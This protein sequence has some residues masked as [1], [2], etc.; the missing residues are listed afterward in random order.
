MSSDTGMDST[1][2][3]TRPCASQSAFIFARDS[4]GQTSPGF[5]SYTAD[6]I[7]RIPGICEMY[8]R[9]I[10]SESPYHRNDIFITSPL[11]AAVRRHFIQWNLAV[12]SNSQAEPPVRP[13]CFPQPLGGILFREEAREC[14]FQEDGNTVFRLSFRRLWAAFYVVCPLTPFLFACQTKT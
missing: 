14:F 12:R 9:E 3:N 11:S 8:S 13:P 1:T 10:G 2:S 6:T 4:S 7:E 5:T